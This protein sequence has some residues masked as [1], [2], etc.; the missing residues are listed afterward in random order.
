MVM[1]LRALGSVAPA[2]VWNPSFDVAPGTLIAGIVTEL[3]VIPRHSDGT[4]QVRRPARGLAA[5]PPSP[6]GRACALVVDT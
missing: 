1:R 6:C 3:G 5:L 2:Q 4:H